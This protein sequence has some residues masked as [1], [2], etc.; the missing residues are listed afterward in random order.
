VAPD[1]TEGK[2]RKEKKKGR[3]LKLVS[4]SAGV[5]G[6]RPNA[7]VLETGNPRRTKPEQPENCC[8]AEELYQRRTGNRCIKKKNRKNL[9]EELPHLG[10]KDTIMNLKEMKVST[11]G[12]E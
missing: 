4:S 3:A 10:P 8:V 11:G 7:S 6:L 5:P 1:Q 12:G 9:D 2:Q